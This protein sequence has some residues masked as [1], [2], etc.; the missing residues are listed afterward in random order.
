MAVPSNTVQTFAAVGIKED[1]SD[2]ITLTDPTETPF[3]S[4]VSKGT[5]KSRTPE[6]MIDSLADPN[7]N[8]KTIEG[9]D[10]DDSTFIADE[11]EGDEDVTDIIGDVSN[12]EDT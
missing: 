4:G 2:I 10:D 1:V 8:N 11:E 7:P 5:R 12:D 3:Y 9:D 6:W